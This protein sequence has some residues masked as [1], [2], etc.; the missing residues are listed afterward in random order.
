VV[1]LSLVCGTAAAQEAAPQTSAATAPATTPETTTTSTSTTVVTSAEPMPAA[2]SAEEAAPA[3]TPEKSCGL[4]N[5]SCKGP[6]IALAIEGGASSYNEGGP[7]GFDTGIGSITKAGPA[8]GLRVGVEVNRWLAFDA[9]YTGT[10]NNGSGVG[11]PNGTV[12]LLTSAAT[13][14]IRLTAPIPYVQPYF[15]T[16]A[17]VYTTSITGDATAQGASPFFGSTEPGV[18]IGLGLSV[19]IADGVSA[20]A[21]LT[22][23]RFFGESFATDEELGGGDLTTMNAVIRARL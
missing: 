6:H 5:H 11:V 2:A 3:P 7:F 12:S 14:E 21:E 22:Y 1:A 23:H 16:G 9:H 4:I 17:G 19:P 10:N 15:F 8:W 18:P 20:G 13:A